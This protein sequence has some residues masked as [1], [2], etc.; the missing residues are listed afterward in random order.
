MRPVRHPVP[1]PDPF[2]RASRQLTTPARG[3]TVVEQPGRDVVQ[4]GQVRGQV[5]LL[6][7]EPD[8][9]RADRGEPPV[10]Q[11]RHVVPAQQHPPARRR[12][13]SAHELQQ[14][15]FPGAGGPDDR[16]QLAVGHGQCGVAQRGDAT[17]VRLGHL[18]HLD[19]AHTRGTRTFIPASNRPVTS[20]SSPAKI[21]NATGTDRTAPAESTTSTA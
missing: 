14:R 5:E 3:H 19:Q 10:R 6:E 2:Q 7:D 8:P 16:D 12:V 4:R 15:G 11:G 9:V 18:D 21:P 20:T 17:A 1:E 13:Q